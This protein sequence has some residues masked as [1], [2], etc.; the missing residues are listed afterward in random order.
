L[1]VKRVDNDA[2][3]DWTGADVVVDFTPSLD[4]T[5]AF[6]KDGVLDGDPTT[7]PQAYV[8]LED[9]DTDSLDAPQLLSVV[10]TALIAGAIDKVRFELP[11]VANS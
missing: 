2:D 4:A 8:D 1:Y 11:L 6:Q 10:V 5:A 3:R 7:A 9:T